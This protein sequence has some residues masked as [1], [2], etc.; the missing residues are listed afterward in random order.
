[1]KFAVLKFEKEFQMQNKKISNLPIVRFLA[2]FLFLFFTSCATSSLNV[3]L[4]ASDQL[5]QDTSGYSYAVLVRFYQL[6]DPSLFEK[7]D[8][9]V[10]FNQD[11]ERLG[12]TLVGKK[13]MMVEPGLTA[14]LS[15]PKVPESKYLGVVAF[16]R[17]A[18]TGQQ[19]VVKKVNYGK[20]PFSTKLELA[21]VKNQV[22]L[23]Y[24]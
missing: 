3:A 23:Q 8:P 18:R 7:S 20:L 13:E 11:E 16:F 19:H 17:D 12:V 22:S 5:N 9:S 14:E 2:P 4:Q 24:R 15:I 6:T 21:L 10:L 1:M